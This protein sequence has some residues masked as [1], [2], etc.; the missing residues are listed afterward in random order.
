MSK[1]LVRS[2]RRHVGD[3]RLRLCPSSVL[4]FVLTALSV[5]GGCDQPEGVGTIDID[6]ARKK[7]I[8]EGK[9]DPL[10]PPPSTPAE[11]EARAKLLRAGGGKP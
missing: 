2:P 11:R 1:L 6:A 9:P 7:A 5:G 8:A 3:S 4:A 10:A